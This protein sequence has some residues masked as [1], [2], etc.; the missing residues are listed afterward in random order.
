MLL[1]VE[2]WILHFWTLLK[3]AVT[4]L[5]LL[6]QL[7]YIIQQNNSI[8]IIQT[9]IQKK[10]YL[11]KASTVQCWS[12]SPID[13]HGQ[14]LDWYSIDISFD[15]SFDTWSTLDWHLINSWLKVGQLL[16][17][18]YASNKNLLT[19]NRNVNLVSIECQP[20]CQ[21]CVHQVV[22][23]GRPR[24]FIVGIDWFS[25]MGLLYT[26]THA[27]HNPSFSSNKGLML[28]LSGCP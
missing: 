22:V 13:T 1:P 5:V 20:R 4:G 11:L 6:S 2:L 21:W 28:K 24:F 25:T 3:G 27:T 16:A 14:Q 26:R 12:M 23:E 17:N 18:S 10:L 15:I 8:I 7:S 19:V 9:S